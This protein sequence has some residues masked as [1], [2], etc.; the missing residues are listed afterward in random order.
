MS[1]L[2]GKLDSILRHYENDGRDESDQTWE[3]FRH[4]L[5]SLIVEHGPKAVNEALDE[6]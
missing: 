2:A 6:I 5:R 1:D 3:G 4:D